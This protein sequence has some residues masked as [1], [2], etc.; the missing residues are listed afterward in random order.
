MSD[1]RTIRVMIRM[2]VIGALLLASRVASAD[3][4]NNEGIHAHVDAML[5]HVD[6]AALD[7]GR[8]RSLLADRLTLNLDILIPIV[9]SCALEEKVFGG[10]RPSAV[11]FDWILGGVLPVGLGATALLGD[12]SLSP[13]ARSVLGW[14]AAGLYASTRLGILIVGNLHISDYNRY[15]KLRL[16]V[17]ESRGG[18]LVPAIAASRSW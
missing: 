17:V 7:A 1:A 10:L 5:S 15:V 13:K 9:G 12:G 18:S 11:V 8:R 2:A 14:T 16:G 4:A 6:V 3:L